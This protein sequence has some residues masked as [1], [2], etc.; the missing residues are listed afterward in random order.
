MKNSQ[1][2][3]TNDELIE[4]NIM[5]LREVEVARDA[6]KITAELV[7]DQFVKLED[8][9]KRLEETLSVEQELKIQLAAKLKE[10]EIREQELSEARSAAEGSNRAKST[11][12]ANMS[13]ELRTPLNAIIGYSE[14]LEEEARDQSLSDLVP[15]LQK[16][17]VAGKHLLNLINDV[18]DL[19]KVEAGK[20]ELF[21]ET[22]EVADLIDDVVSTIQPLINK[23]SNRLVIDISSGIGTIESDI[24]RLRQCLFNLLSNACKFTKDGE[25]RM[26]VTKEPIEDKE[27][28]HFS[29][30]D[31][32]IGMTEEQ[33][34]RIFDAFSQADLST[35]RKFGGTGLGLAITRRLCQ[36]MGGDVNVESKYG[37]GTTF[38]VSIPGKKEQE[39]KS[40]DA[41]PGA[42]MP[43]KAEPGV[44]ESSALVLVIDDEA[45]SR[46]LIGHFLTREGFTVRTASSGEEGLKLARQ[47][48]PAV[49][50]LDIIMPH[51]DGWAVLDAIKADPEIADI[52]VVVVSV[53]D[54]Q[55]LGFA[56][57]AM[58]YVTKPIDWDHLCDLLAKYTHG[59]RD[60]D[61]LLVEDDEN[62][63][64]IMRRTLVKEGWRLLE[65]ENGRV[66][67]NL[68]ENETPG[69]IILDLMMPEM[70]GF[71][72]LSELRKKEEW[73]KI[74]V[75]VV[76]AKDL[77]SNEKH[78]LEGRVQK[79]IQKGSY[80]KKHLLDQVKEIV[81]RH[82]RLED[83]GRK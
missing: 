56:V 59:N 19:S 1:N 58:A 48:K 79:I 6:S 54:N 21:I 7:V 66:A 30:S 42:V 20:I 44:P 52:P 55:K 70:D 75:I 71:E 13:H 27:W 22:I 72:F 49:I 10:A 46:E 67:I 41:I 53:T 12:L 45:D 51:M 3:K 33:M 23:N 35:T 37:E 74:P 43:A 34:G 16:I 24:T 81:S 39:A 68:M 78:Q 61:I 8:I 64:Q 60:I 5:L 57:G 63:R 40:E 36:R 17:Q 83:R 82:A 32:G 77:S 18:L 38:T 73:Q 31:N 62:T 11:F 69:L 9:L 14:M 76:T 65:A 25:I 4:E 15:D 47:L 80:T 50:T 26:R 29:V 28:F 2:G